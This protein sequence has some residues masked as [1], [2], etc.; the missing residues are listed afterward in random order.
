MNGLLPVGAGGLLRPVLLLL[1]RAPSAASA[2]PAGGELLQP[3]SAS[4][5][6]PTAVA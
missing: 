2:L 5:A 4:M 1:L 3:A 6:L